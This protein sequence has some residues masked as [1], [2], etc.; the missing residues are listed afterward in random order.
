VP[1]S[2]SR[3]HETRRANRD[4]RQRIDELR[5]QQ[6]ASERRKNVLFAGGG[7]IVAVGLILAA[8]IPAYLHDRHQKANAKQ[9]TKVLQ[10]KPTAAETAAGCTGV[11]QDPVS[12]A[13]QHVTTA[14]DYTKEKY[15]DTEGGT[16]AI[17]PEASTTRS[18][19]AT[20][21]A[22]IPWRRSRARSGRCTTSS[23]ATSSLGMTPNS[24]PAK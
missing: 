6:R 7:I 20:P 21:T 14:I 24:R 16:P 12:P 5:K 11:H 15:G 19:S 22:S 4:R 9:A 13:A 17:P 10:L 23:T 8:V 1:K 18:H 3:K 2:S